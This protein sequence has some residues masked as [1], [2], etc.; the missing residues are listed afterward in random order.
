MLDNR[1]NLGYIM[2]ML[3]VALITAM[4][5]ND[6]EIPRNICVNLGPL[7]L[8]AYA[9]KMGAKAEIVI[10]PN[11]DE[12]IAYKPDIVAIS[13]VTEFYYIAS[14]IAK[15]CKRELCVPVILG[16][17]H[18]TL[19]P[20]SIHKN[21]D[22]GIIS[23]GEETFCDL[24]NFFSSNKDFKSLKKIKG[25]VYWDDDKLIYT[26]SRKLIS[27]LDKIPIPD[28]KR[29][30]EKIGLP[31]IVTTRGCPFH[32]SFC[33][34]PNL[35][36]K[37]REHSPKRVVEE[38][39]QIV[40][41]FNPPHIRFFDD[42]FTLNK[43]RLQKI[44]KL[45]KK[46][47]LTNNMTFG[48]W[49]RSDLIDEE[50]VDILKEMNFFYVAIGIESATNS[51]LKYLKGPRASIE[52]HQRAID[53]IY[54]AGMKVSLSFLIGSPHETRE[55]L[56]KIYDF[57]EL[58][59]HKLLEIEINALVPQPTTPLWNYAMEKGLV[60]YDM[61]WSKLKDHSFK[62]DINKDNFIYLNE[63]MDFEEFIE[64]KDKLAQFYS[65]INMK[66][67]HMELAPKLFKLDQIPAKIKSHTK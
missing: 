31:H 44:L 17:N 38:L 2:R 21:I 52:Q 37:Y 42:I 15:R 40:D 33:S 34:T 57:I 39:K 6:T 49:S 8:E 63:K 18:I 35:W 45:M 23:E 65:R 41:D 7:Y 10:F 13:S 4:L 67:E 14:Q 64:M 25:I 19:C 48:G 30:V 5:E 12:L 36:K 51:I 61:D 50:I 58:N 1:R 62:L 24:I 32:C 3:K 66:P 53:L 16:G 43:K 56:E 20:Q 22:I 29:W 11:V 26:K 28:R 46:E 54:N 27:N 47:G 59:E 9:K 55:D 60:S